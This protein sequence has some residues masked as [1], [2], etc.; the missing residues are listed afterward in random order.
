MGELNHDSRN[1]IAHLVITLAPKFERKDTKDERQRL[2][3]DLKTFGTIC[4][5]YPWDPTN[6]GINCPV[7]KAAELI[8][9][10]DPNRSDL[11]DEIEVGDRSFVPCY[12]G[13]R[14]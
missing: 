8:D 4:G 12:T 5:D 11:V 7:S 10:Y 13:Y 14:A 1:G 6:I 2:L 3:D 9:R